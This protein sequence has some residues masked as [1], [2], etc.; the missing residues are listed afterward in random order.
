[1]K[2][3]EYR[4]YD[5]LG[6]ADLVNNG[7]ITAVELAKLTFEGITA[8]NPDLNGVV[9]V[10][11]DQM[12]N[13]AVTDNTPFAGVPFLVK[14]L[15]LNIE[16]RNSE[17]GSRLCQGMTAP[18]NSH[19]A[20]KYEK[21]GLVTLGRTATPE[22]GFNITTESLV[23]GPTRNP[24]N[25]ELMPGGSSGGSAAMVASGAVPIAHGTDGCGSIR[26]PAGCCGLVGLKPSRGRISLGPNTG[27]GLNGLGIEHVLTRSLRDS[28]A[29]L[30]A[31]EGPMPGDPYSII[32]PH[33]SYLSELNQTCEPLKVGFTSMAWSGDHVD[34]EIAEKTKK[35]ALL[36]A[37][38]G[39]YVEE[40]SPRIDY[41]SFREATIAFWCSNVALWINQISEVMGRPVN[42]ATLETTT[43]AC[44]QYG[45][46]MKATDMVA[47]FSVMNMV[48]RE[49]AGFFEKY[50]VLI[51]PT[52]ALLP[53]KIGTYNS[54]DTT[55]DAHGWFDHI[56]SFAPFT[57]L[58]NMTG[59][60]A[61]SLPLSLSATGLPI[62]TQFIGASGC[63][64]MLFRL[65]SQLE[66]AVPWA[67]RHPEV[68]LWNEK[69]SGS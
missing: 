2:L 17:M 35:I 49:V 38:M 57:A 20:T 3:S 23:N 50:D 48:S 42:L 24:W 51:T 5:A 16:G 63:E 1:M 41:G 65:S 22:M 53:Q 28:A 9:E 8:L 33:R 56:F 26:I 29:I 60:P 4:N 67:D 64:D 43:L 66:Q 7:D 62:G 27:E 55:L 37:D 32:Q 39:H 30:D 12:D 10:F 69:Y 54:N 46:E 52:T 21:A 31:T 68:S 14:D 61:I 13:F 58:F 11:E 40:A 6:L 18:Y 19:L 34:A 36:C 59:Q 44:H 25:T 15:I 47:A 45:R